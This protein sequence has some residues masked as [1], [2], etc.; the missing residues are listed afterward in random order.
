MKQAVCLC[1]A[2]TMQVTSRFAE[3]QLAAGSRPFALLSAAR[4]TKDHGHADD[5]RSLQIDEGSTHFHVW[6][7]FMTA[8]PSPG[9]GVT[10]WGQLGEEGEELPTAEGGTVRCA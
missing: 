6:S 7:E 8:A 1:L 4:N 9:V 5:I 3:I 2:G 10:L